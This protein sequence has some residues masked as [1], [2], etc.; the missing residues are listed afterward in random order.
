MDNKQTTASYLP[1]GSSIETMDLTP[2]PGK[3]HFTTRTL[4]LVSNDSIGSNFGTFSCI[5]EHNTSDAIGL[6]HP[7]LFSNTIH[8][9][10]IHANSLHAIPLQPIS[11]YAFIHPVTIHPVT[12]HPVAVYTIS[13]YDVSIHSVSI[14]PNLD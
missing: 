8:S 11:L 5:D 14:H 4:Q 2:G 13:V 1:I 9:V 10:T 7:L 12:I 3:V 6:G